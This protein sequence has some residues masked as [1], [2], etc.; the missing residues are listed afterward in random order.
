MTVKY[1]GQAKV[2]AVEV[3]N[4]NVDADFERL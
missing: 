3:W 1:K 4:I 2:T